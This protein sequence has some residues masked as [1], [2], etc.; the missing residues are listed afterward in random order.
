[1]TLKVFEAFSG[2]GSQRK[3]LDNLGIDHEVVA[4][5]EI[6]KHAIASYEAIYGKTKNVGDISKLTDEEVPECDLFTYSFPCTDI[7]NA[8]EKKGL[9]KD[10]GTKSSLLWECERIIKA[11]KPKYLM[12]ENVKNLA[13]KKHRHNFDKW[14]EILES[15]GYNNYWQVLNAKDY[16]I[17]QNRERIFVISVRK[18]VDDGKFKFQ[19]PFELKTT[20]FDLLDDEV[21]D[22]LWLSEKIKK[23]FLKNTKNYPRADRFLSNINPNNPNISRCLV[24]SPG[25]HN[26]DQILKYKNGEITTEPFSKED[27]LNNDLRRLST[28]ECWRLMGFDDESYQKAKEVVSDTQLRRQ[29]GNSIVV[30]VLEGIFK[31]LFETEVYR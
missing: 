22:N 9:D 17:P 13:G 14:L 6:D 11:A 25:L 28:K 12:L 8:G 31:N 15:Y 1:M 18:D 19:E 27:V 20:L 29:A 24:Q 23:G 4:I 7:S 30:N 5:S 2:I 3:A 10:S 26:T 21:S 16:G